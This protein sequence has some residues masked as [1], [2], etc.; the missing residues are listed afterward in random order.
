MY[1][2]TS[3]NHKRWEQ[4]REKGRGGGESWSHL[5]DTV[6]HTHTARSS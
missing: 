4:G 1:E 6:E 3:E 2:E 5:G